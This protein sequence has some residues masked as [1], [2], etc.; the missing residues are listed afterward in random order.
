MPR[1]GMGAQ[2]HRSNYGTWKKQTRDDDGLRLVGEQKFVRLDTL[3]QWFAPGYARAPA[4][5]PLTIRPRRN[6]AAIVLRWD[7]L[8]INGTG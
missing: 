6:M 4:S 7:G 1:K 8:T 3:C 5:I 2:S